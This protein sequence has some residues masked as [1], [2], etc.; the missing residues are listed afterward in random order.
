MNPDTI[1]LLI[2]VSG[3]AMAAILIL[4]KPLGGWMDYALAAVVLVSDIVAG[5]IV[6]AILSRKN[7]G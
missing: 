2:V 6:H 3:L 7:R 1:R 4:L 5:Q